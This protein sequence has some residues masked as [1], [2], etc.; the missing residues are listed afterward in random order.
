VTFEEVGS[1]QTRLT[2]TRSHWDVGEDE[3]SKQ[4]LDKLAA[5]VAELAKAV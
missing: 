5:F 3:G 1:S 4:I 2:F